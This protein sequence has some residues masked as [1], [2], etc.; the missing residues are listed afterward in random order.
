MQQRKLGKTGLTVSALGYG[1]APVGYLAIEQQQITDILNLLLDNGINLIDTAASY[2]GSEEA[3]G[4]AIAHRRSEY[5]LVSK[6]GRTIEAS[7]GEAWSAQVILDT[8]DQSLARLKTDHLDV[9]LLHS[10]DLE[11][12]KRGEAL[13]ALVQAKKAGKIRFAGYSGDNDAGA[14]AAT[15][16]EVSV[17]ETSISIADQANIERVLPLCLL[18][19]VGVLAK[20][21]IANAAWKNPADQPGMYRDYSAVYTERLQQMQ[22]NPA[23]LGFTQ[24]ASEAWPEMALRYTLM[25]PGVS[26]AIIGT[27]R[28]DNAKKNIEAVSRGP[29]PAAVEKAIWDAFKREAAKCGDWTART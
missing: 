29:L 10:C 26:S 1:A 13:G 11:T 16:P 17:I 27:T 19:H 5:T 28:I 21:P 22:L 8:V 23:A 9:M 15:L 20:R 12:L 2:P 3:I 4:R 7:S 18:N 25:Q 24:P 6:C 14:Y